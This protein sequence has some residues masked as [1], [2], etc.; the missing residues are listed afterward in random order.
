MTQNVF[1]VNRYCRCVGTNVNQG[2]SRTFLRLRKHAV[3]QCQRRKIELGNANLCHFEAVVKA[4]IEGLTLQDVEEVALKPGAL[5]ANRVGLKLRVN[6]ILL[7]C[8]V[9]EL[10]IRIL[11]IAV[12]IHQ[13][14][15]HLLCYKRVGRQVTGDD[16]TYASY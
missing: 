14:N 5:D 12:G 9:N 7:D 6:L 11:H 2:T 1:V 16:V 8:H 13:F 4:L 3:S 10:L 15:D